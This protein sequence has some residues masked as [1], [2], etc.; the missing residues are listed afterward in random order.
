MKNAILSVNNFFN[1]GLNDKSPVTKAAS[2]TLITGIAIGTLGATAATVSLLALPFITAGTISLACLGGS[3]LLTGTCLAIKAV[4]NANVR[5]SAVINANV[6]SSAV[7]NEN[8]RSSAVINENVRSS[9]VINEN[10][11]SSAVIK[12]QEQFRMHSQRKR[13]ELE[14]AVKVRGQLVGNFKD[15]NKTETP[16]VQQSID[17]S[18][19]LLP[20]QLKGIFSFL[21]ESDLRSVALTQK[22]WLKP[23]CDIRIQRLLL[24]SFYFNQAKQYSYCKDSEKY[25]EIAKSEAK[26]GLIDAAEKTVSTYNNHIENHTIYTPYLIPPKRKNYILNEYTNT[27][28]LLTDKE[29]TIQFISCR[30]A[31]ILSKRHTEEQNFTKA[32]VIIEQIKCQNL[33]NQ[34]LTFLA[35]KQLEVHQLE[36][37]K[38]TA[39]NIQD[40]IFGTE[41]LSAIAIEEAR[42]KKK[43]DAKKTFKDAIEKAH[44]AKCYDQETMLLFTIAKQLGKTELFNPKDLPEEELKS[45]GLD[46]DDRTERTEIAKVEI[47]L[48]AGLVDAAVVTASQI[49]NLFEKGKALSV[50]AEYHA[51][52]KHFEHAKAF[53]KKID[54]CPVRK[55][56]TLTFI[57]KK[58]AEAKYPF[59]ARK[60]FND[61]KKTILERKIWPCFKVK[62]LCKIAQAQTKYNFLNDAKDTLNVAKQ[63]FVKEI[64]PQY[65]HSYDTTQ[66]LIELAKTQAQSGF[67]DDAKNTFAFAIENVKW[68]NAYMVRIAEIQAGFLQQKRGRFDPGL[69]EKVNIKFYCAKAERVSTIAPLYPEKC[70]SIEDRLALEYKKTTQNRLDFNS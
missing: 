12:F 69:S 16:A 2:I 32:R 41:V 58:E 10:V 47:Q 28:H 56:E 7:I 35:Y 60:T 6:R 18:V 37:A 33:K 70:L 3:I 8:V 17:R 50:I 63:H 39:K 54:F 65:L 15:T 27:I 29:A 14:K 9:A 67:L 4:I 46:K 11:R 62:F 55:T 5:S 34:A 26:M 31:Q 23:A 43:D 52:A 13:F 68:E 25:L 20:F 49:Q 53:T 44:T 45:L 30:K 51:E 24:P 22:K 42:Q 36:D 64:D 1:Q 48:R 21:S 38:L 59:G 40:P 66:T 57:G 19:F 61:A